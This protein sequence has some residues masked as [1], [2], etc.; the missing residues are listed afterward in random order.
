[1]SAPETNNTVARPEKASAYWSPYVAGFGLGLVLLASL[2]ILGAGLGASGGLARLAAWM[3]HG[4]A[5]T[6]VERSAYF[7]IWF[8]PEAPHVLKYYLVFM[9]L[10]IVVGAALSALGSGR[11]SPSIEK[12]PH[13]ST[14]ARLGFALGGGVLVGFA[15]RLARGCTSGQALTG[16]ALLLTGSIVFLICLFLG[17]YAAAYFVRREWL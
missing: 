14:P 8:A 7:G 4:L 1:M 6:H 3:Q 13:V 17:G 10:G 12:G 5:P 9:M 2:W 11:M 16:T 15:S